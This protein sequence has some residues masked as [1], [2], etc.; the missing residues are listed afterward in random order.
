MDPAA[1]STSPSGAASAAD[2]PVATSNGTSRSAPPRPPID[3]MAAAPAAART[4]SGVATKRVSHLRHRC[5]N[6]RP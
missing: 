3:P 2:V 4:R 1:T 5:Q 6:P